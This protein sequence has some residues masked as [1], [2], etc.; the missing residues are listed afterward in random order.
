MQLLPAEGKK[1]ERYRRRRA[2]MWRNVPGHGPRDHPVIGVGR[3]KIDRN[4]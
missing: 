2:L 3:K 4:K 1:Q